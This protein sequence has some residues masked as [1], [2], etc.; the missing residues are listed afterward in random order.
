VAGLRGRVVEEGSEGS[1]R[2]GQRG[3]QRRSSGAADGCTSLP[4]EVHRA[5][6]SCGAPL[7]LLPGADPRMPVVTVLVLRWQILEGFSQETP[8]TRDERC[9]LPN[10]FCLAQVSLGSSVVPPGW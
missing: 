1:S 2:K 4:E 7:A 3:R 5:A 10:S 6:R 8:S 9:D